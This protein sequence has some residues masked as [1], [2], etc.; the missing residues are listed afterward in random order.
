MPDTLALG[1]NWRL[2]D[3][4]I[5][6]LAVPHPNQDGWTAMVWQGGR[7]YLSGTVVYPE[8]LAEQLPAGTALPKA[9]PEPPQSGLR[10][11]RLVMG[12]VMIVALA[13][14]VALA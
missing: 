10:P 3:G 12:L 5:V 6:Q 7:W 11:N 4:T 1:Q 2:H 13:L 8:D 14:I 9:P